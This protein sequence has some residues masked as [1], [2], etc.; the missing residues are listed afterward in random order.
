MERDNVMA[1]VNELRNSFEDAESREGILNQ[2]SDEISALYDANT[3]LTNSN[4][5]Y[6]SQ[7]EQLRAANMKLFL[8]VG[9]Q[10]IE[11]TVQ[12]PAEDTVKQPLKFEDLFNE[13]GE[14][15]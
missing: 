1:L 7:N 3:T 14:L 12:Q 8:Q 9:A 6:I 4:S 11:P 10:A 13:K 2:I 5:E 15:K